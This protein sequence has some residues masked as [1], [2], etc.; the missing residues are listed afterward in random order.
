MR[1]NGPRALVFAGATAP[2]EDVMVKSHSSSKR[3]ALT[4]LAVLTLLV[5]VTETASSQTVTTLHAFTRK[6]GDGSFPTAG[7]ILDGKGNLYG[8]TKT[9]G[10]GGRPGGGTVFELD[11]SGTVVQNY[12]LGI[13]PECGYFPEA[14]LLKIKKNL[15]GTTFTGGSC[16][17]NDG[18][19]SVFELSFSAKKKS[20]VGKV[21]YSFTGGSFGPDGF[22]PEGNLI[23]DE[24][25]NLYGT[26]AY[27]GYGY[28]TVFE[29]TPSGT[30]T[31]LYRFCPDEQKGCTDGSLPQ[32]GLVRDAEGNLYGA[33]Y[34]GGDVS[35][36][37]E[38]IDGCGTVFEL[39]PSGQEIV[40]HSFEGPDGAN[41]EAG[42]IR[43]NKGNLYGTTINGGTGGGG[44]AVFMVTPAGA[45]KVFYAF[46]GSPDGSEPVAALLRDRK[47]N[48][49]GTTVAGGNSTG[50][51]DG[52]ITECGTIFEVTPD[53]AE[54][55]LYRF[56]G[57][58]DG[59]NPQ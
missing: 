23:A 6:N 4:L 24:Q 21:L 47:G 51:A 59:G 34:Y 38:G 31:V 42:L 29:V 9:G 43:D 2:M 49:Y 18:S 56:T 22:F 50:C 11:P 48:L 13:Y 44:G 28:G 35:G 52:G 14:S 41:P 15:Y 33:T 57:G 55:V 17:G 32:G 16:S 20:Y 37:C 7:L 58:E 53:G 30:E 1:H 27:G 39:T 12:L 10:S 36:G 26:T 54:T 45:E 8:T 25:G 40:V 5:A 46:Q 19:G 3:V